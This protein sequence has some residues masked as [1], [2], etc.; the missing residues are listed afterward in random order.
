MRIRPQSFSGNQNVGAF[1][2]SGM[3]PEN[4]FSAASSA[5]LRG[6]GPGATL[7]LLNGRRLAYNGYANTIDIGMIPLP[8]LDR[9]EVV[10]DGAS[11]LRSEE[12][13]SE[14]QSLM[15]NSYAV[16]CLKKKTTH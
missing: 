10:T 11:A 7:T 16:F 3:A 5:D 15:R 9:V 2:I 14:L 13:T 4:N 12:H 1:P 6:L 8:A